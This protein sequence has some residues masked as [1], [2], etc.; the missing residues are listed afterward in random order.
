M[1]L[2]PEPAGA[3]LPTVD[4]IADQINGIGI[5]ISQKLEKL[6]G[7]AAACAEMHVGNKEGAKLPYALPERH[8]A[9]SRALCIRIS[10]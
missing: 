8:R 9:N 1:M 5:V 3:Q 7:L 2:R 10:L 4:N 6:F